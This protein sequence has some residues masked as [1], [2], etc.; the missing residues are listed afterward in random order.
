[1]EVAAEGVETTEQVTWLRG[2]GCDRLQ[3]YAISK[4]MPASAIKGFMTGSVSR[5]ET[6]P[7]TPVTPDKH[8]RL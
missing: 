8:T 1:M 2:L 3:G 7:R 5:P 4:P 6:V